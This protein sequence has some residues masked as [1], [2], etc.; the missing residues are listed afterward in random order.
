MASL[1]AILFALKLCG[2]LLTASLSKSE[3]LL[4][5][6]SWME[7]DGFGHSC[8]VASD[9]RH[10]E[11]RIHGST[12]EPCVLQVSS[13]QYPSHGIRVGIQHVQSEQDITDAFV[14]LYIQGEHSSDCPANISAVLSSGI[15][16]L[17]ECQMIFKTHNRSLYIN[18]Q[19]H[20][21][22]ILSEIQVESQPMC[23]DGA[24]GTTD[25]YSSNC[26]HVKWYSDMITCSA[27]QKNATRGHYCR[28]D[29]DLRYN[30]SFT[31]HREVIFTS[32]DTSLNHVHGGVSQTYVSVVLY[33]SNITVLDL[34]YNNVILIETNSF[35][36]L[37]R[38]YTLNLDGNF[39]E[40]LR[41]QTFYG[42]GNLFQLL[43]SGNRLAS[44]HVHVFSGLRR[45]ERLELNGNRLATLDVG[46]FA[47]L[48]NLLY[49]DLQGNRFT[50]LESN[51]FRSLDRLTYLTL[52]GN[53]LRSLDL[54]PF[55]VLDGLMYLETL[56]LSSNL[57]GSLDV[58]IFQGFKKLCVLSLHTNRLM[59]LPVNLLNGLYDLAHLYLNINQLV[60]LHANVF[61]DLKSLQ[62]LILE[63][64]LLSSIHVH[65][66]R[67]LSNVNVIVMNNNQLQ[68]LQPG[69][70][71]DLVDLNTLG[72]SNNL[73]E[74]LD[75]NIF[76]TTTNLTSIN[77]F[78]NRL[79]DIPNIKT[80][81]HLGYFNL[82][83]NALTDVTHDSF[84]GLPESSVL[85][86]NQHEI[87]ECYVSSRCSAAD[88]R[89][90]YLTCDRLLSDRVLMIMMWIIGLNAL[91]GNI[92]VLTWR[93]KTT[94]TNQVQT[95][96]L[97]NLAASDLLMGVYMIIIASADMYFA[98]HF[99]MQ[100]E[101]WRYSITCKIAGTL[102]ITSSE[103]SVFFVTLISLDRYIHIKFPYSQKQIN[104][105][106]AILISSV[107]WI[108]SLILGIVPSFLSGVNFKFYDNSHVCI[109][110]PLALTKVYSTKEFNTVI[111]S[112]RFEGLSGVKNTFITKFEGFSNGLYYS[113][114]VFLGLN[115]LC[116]LAILA[117]YISII[118]AVKKSSKRSGRSREMTEQ[119][120]LT[121]KVTVIVATDFFCWFPVIILGILVQTRIVTLPAS[122]YAWIVTFVLPINSAI[123]PFLYTIPVI[124]SNLREKRA[125]KS[126]S[127]DMNLS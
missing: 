122:I 32:N 42:L 8:T 43:L 126:I 2:I 59:T 86:V 5:S 44:I 36:G 119:M 69:V 56:S 46:V 112:S 38:L 118:R 35:A 9:I 18:L 99:P 123:N 63:S 52:A 80:L 82:W 106:S 90:P 16:H 19:G 110:L 67:G 48:K 14:L 125:A 116:Y 68:R 85:Y 65:A 93:N 89:S 12:D 47:D 64:N 20:I 77:L 101:S 22:L 55:R 76:E 7:K 111:H 66:F 49:L 71:A 41:A 28:L 17:E 45:L 26:T 81:T 74:W 100:S 27:H 39:L 113:V 13:T 94:Q 34:S 10:G 96:L 21:S 30:V 92:I 117:C 53:Q 103:A 83:N 3:L 102:S 104:K 114:A 73:I 1:S 72:L 4:E 61:K 50:T 70:F 24:T 6:S 95:I 11:L 60:A 40:T 79:K 127:Q 51:V 91:F 97:C 54:L 15:H 62:V 31:S 107:I 75:K 87:C 120:S 84:V 25:I 37:H 58:N 33:P 78:S 105:Q 115:L 108:F 98:E 121:A 29:V 57:L 88:N 109:G 124:I 23:V